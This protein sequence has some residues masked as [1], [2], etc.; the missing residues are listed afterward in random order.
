MKVSVSLPD[1]DVAYLDGYAAKVGQSRSAAVQRAIRLLRAAELGA[2][3][4]AAWD[5]WQAGPDAALWEG[6]VGDGLAS[7]VD[8]PGRFAESGIRQRNNPSA[9]PAMICPVSLYRSTSP[10]FFSPRRFCWSFRKSSRSPMMP[11]HR[12]STIAISKYGRLRLKRPHSTTEIRALLRMMSPPI[13]GVDP[14]PA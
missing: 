7:D 8:A 6:A 13:V 9:R 5:E 4:E 11:I 2:A 1:D 14:F 12:V 10:R 3:Y